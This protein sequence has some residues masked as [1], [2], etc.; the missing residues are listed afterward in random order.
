MKVA[1]K[2]EELQLQQCRWTRALIK[3]SIGS[4]GHAGSPCAGSECGFQWLPLE[5]DDILG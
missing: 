3:K 4:N 5:P 1:R 2:V